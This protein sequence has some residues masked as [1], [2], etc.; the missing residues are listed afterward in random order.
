MDSTFRK[1][2]RLKNNL[3]IQDLIRH[4]HTVSSFP[5]KLY[6][7]TVRDPLQKYPARIAISIPKKNFRRAVDR[8]LMKRR[9]RESYRKNKHFLN[10]CLNEADLKALMVVLL[11]SNE[12]MPYEIIESKL[13]VLLSKMMVDVNKSG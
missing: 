6:W 12:L 7:K 11:V 9:I 5:L 4:G 3:A 1:E 10:A 8:N 13:K 2:E